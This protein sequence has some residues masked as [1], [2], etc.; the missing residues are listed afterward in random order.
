MSSPTPSSGASITNRQDLYAPSPSDILNQ[1]IYICTNTIVENVGSITKP[2]HIHLSSSPAPDSKHKQS[3]LIAPIPLPQPLTMASQNAASSS[4]KACV[5]LSGF[6]G[7]EKTYLAK[8]PELAP[9]YEILDLDSSGFSKDPNGN[10]RPDFPDNYSEEVWESLALNKIILVSAHQKLRDKFVE[11]NLVFALVYP[12]RDAKDQWI[13]RLK[14]RGSSD[15]LVNLIQNNWDAMI[16]SCEKQTQ[17]RK[18]PLKEGEN[19]SDIIEKLAQEMSGPRK[20]N[21]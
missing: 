19:L 9:G 21:L 6:A 2:P 1:R 11:D 17:C 10:D 14:S 4:W 12:P 8:H 16:D 13:A 7:I 3:R 20:R 5:V 15:A 18:F